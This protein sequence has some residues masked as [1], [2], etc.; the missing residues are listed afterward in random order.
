MQTNISES[1]GSSEAFQYTWNLLQTCLKTHHYCRDNQRSPLPRRVLDLGDLSLGPTLDDTSIKLYE[2]KGEAAAYACLSHCWG[3]IQPLKTTIATS[4]AHKSG[5]KWAE[6]PKTFQ[7][8]IIFTKRL[9]VRYIW[10]DS[11]CII[12]DDTEDW[13]TEAQKMCAIYQGSIL[14][15]SATKSPGP[16]GGCFAEAEPEYRGT[17]VEGEYR[18]KPYQVYVRRLMSH[19]EYTQ[20][21][22]TQHQRQPLLQRAWVLQERLLGPRALHFGPQ[23]LLWECNEAS[24]CQC[25]SAT[26]VRCAR[27]IG[28]RQA[29]QKGSPAQIADYWRELVAKYSTLQ[30][31]YASDRLPALSGLATQFKEFRKDAY[32]AGVWQDSMVED[33][34][35]YVYWT[36]P[37]TRVERG[38]IPSWSWASVNANISFYPDSVTI[39]AFRKVYISELLMRQAGFDKNLTGLVAGDCL[40]ACGFLAKVL[41]LIAPAPQPNATNKP[42]FYYLRPDVQTKAIQF[43]ADYLIEEASAEEHRQLRTGQTLYCLKF[44]DDG[45]WLYSLVL[46]C[47]DK[48]SWVFERVGIVMQSLNS[49]QGGHEADLYKG[50][51]YETGVIVV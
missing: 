45:K 29:L 9:E 39:K 33:L 40:M 44:A 49:I 7:E 6:F 42:W 8:A 17:R 12:Q 27:K 34:M 20:A 10:I 47:L 19:Q 21:A 1:T 11:L 4:E 23:E 18:G 30:L 24:T 25:N 26:F 14:T 15:L 32:N 28:H 46:Q 5:I 41:L 36:N 3:G 13:K 16:R 48:E 35:W 37:A 22:S 51:E 43:N 38:K 31:T 50:L 2:T